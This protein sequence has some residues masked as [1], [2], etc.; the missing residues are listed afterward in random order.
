MHIAPGSI[1]Y[2]ERTKRYPGLRQR[3]NP[4][5]ST[6]NYGVGAKIAAAPRNRAGLTYLSWK[7]SIGYMIHL[8]RDQILGIMVCA[9]LELPDGGIGY[10]AYV[11]DDVKPSLIDQ[12][13]TIVVLLGNEINAD[14][15]TPPVG[16]PSPSRWITRYLNTR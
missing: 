11:Q 10:W 4:R 1:L 6:G 14:T 16:T 3:L 13:G 2:Q 5:S 9:S 8:W 7:D 15:L 12:H